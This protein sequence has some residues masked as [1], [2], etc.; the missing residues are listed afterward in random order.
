LTKVKL[1]PNNYKIKIKFLKMKDFEE[2]N[3]K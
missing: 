1:N 3:L 2:R